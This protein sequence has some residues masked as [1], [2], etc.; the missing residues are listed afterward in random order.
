MSRL[1]VGLI[2]VFLLGL[3]IACESEE[4]I[5]KQIGTATRVPET[6]ERI[7]SFTE[8]RRTTEAKRQTTEAINTMTPVQRVTGETKTVTPVQQVTEETKTVT[9]AQ[10][11]TAEQL[12]A[13]YEA[14]EIAADVKYKGNIV[15]VTGT[16]SDIGRDFLNENPYI[17]LVAG[18]LLGAMALAGVECKF[19]ESEEAGIASL[20][21]GE[22]ITVTGKVEGKTFIGVELSGCT[23]K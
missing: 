20:S 8:M 3:I 16:V 4:D 15:V 12:F 10:Q 1:L 21:K 22:A 18:G 2:A 23:L 19:P 5:A 6:T 13:E 7:L 11:V 17:I 14:N 9:T